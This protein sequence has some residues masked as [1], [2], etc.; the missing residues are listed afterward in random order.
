[1]FIKKILKTSLIKKVNVARKKLQARKTVDSSE[2]I[3]LSNLN[4]LPALITCPQT[5]QDYS[6][7]HE[8][9]YIHENL[10]PSI[11]FLKGNIC[12]LDL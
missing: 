3:P 7:L 1:M 9:G 11:Q 5:D 2:S 6:I 12:R 8:S 4:E 10:P